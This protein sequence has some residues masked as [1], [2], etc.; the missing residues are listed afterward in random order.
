MTSGRLLI[1]NFD[2]TASIIIR[3]CKYS[4]LQNSCYWAHRK[5]SRTL[6]MVPSSTKWPRAWDC[7]SDLLPLSPSGAA[8]FYQWRAGAGLSQLTARDPTSLFP[9]PGSV[10]SRRQLEIGHGRSINIPPT[11]THDKSGL[12]SKTLLTLYRHAAADCCP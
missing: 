12:L 2:H 8:P 5:E 4:P 11:G 10:A 9:F 3:S 7:D 6:S 1:L